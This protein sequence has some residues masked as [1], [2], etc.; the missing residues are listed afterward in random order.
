MDNR[1][2]YQATAEEGVCPFCGEFVSKGASV[3]GNCQAVH[4]QQVTAG[5]FSTII[6][7][8]MTI[9]YSISAWLMTDYVIV[10]MIV[11]VVLMYL[12]MLWIGK[13]RTTIGWFRD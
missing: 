10:G 13:Y 4:G 11:F 12:H 8:S 9:L 2:T 3:C 1:F 5:S 7:L 6:I